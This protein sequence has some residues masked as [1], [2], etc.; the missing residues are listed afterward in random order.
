MIMN[1][2][3]LEK[4]IKSICIFPYVQASWRNDVVSRTDQAL[5]CIFSSSRSQLILIVFPI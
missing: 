3:T 1:I 2:A 4:D 5:N